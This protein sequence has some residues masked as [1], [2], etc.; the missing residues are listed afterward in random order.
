MQ[1]HFLANVQ[2]G[3]NADNAVQVE[4][5]EFIGAAGAAAL[6]GKVDNVGIA[7][8]SIQLVQGTDAGNIGQGLDIQGK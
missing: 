3:M 1:Q 2:Y 7:D 6:Q 8:A 4:G 5:H